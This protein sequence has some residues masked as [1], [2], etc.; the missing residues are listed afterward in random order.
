MVD[1]VFSMY[2]GS[3]YI[4]TAQKYPGVPQLSPAQIEVLKL[5]DE[6]TYEPGMAIAM[7][8]RPGDIQWLSNYA[9]LHSRTSFSDHPE[10]QRRRHL[11]RLWLH[12]D[13]GR[14]VVAGFGKNGV[15]QHRDRPR[16]GGTEHP[17][18]RFRVMESAVPRLIA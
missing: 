16:N 10:A 13:S 12:R 17:E 9:A 15:V 18:A 1:G 5:F 6:I 4:L 7:D 14:P 3:L 11:L 8:F 2:A